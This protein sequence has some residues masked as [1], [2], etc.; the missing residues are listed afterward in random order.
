MPNLAVATVVPTNVAFFIN[1][2]L[3]SNRSVAPFSVNF[4]TNALGDYTFNA[5]LMYGGGIN[6]TSVPVSFSVTPVGFSS[7][8][9]PGSVALANGMME[10]A[11]PSATTGSYAIQ[12]SP[13]LSPGSWVTVTNITGTGGSVSF[14]APQSPS[15]AFFRWLYTP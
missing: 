5:V 3:Y 4:T 7:F 14:S 8:I 11:F 12:S 9:Q 13:D 2:L 1:G 15:N 6:S 10:F